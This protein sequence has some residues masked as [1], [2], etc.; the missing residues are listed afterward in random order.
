MFDEPYFRFH[1]LLEHLITFEHI[2]E[3]YNLEIKTEIDTLT[4]S[5]T[6]IYYIRR[7]DMPKLDELA[8]QYNID[9]VDD[10]AP[11][12]REH[13]SLQRLPKWLRIPAIILILIYLYFL[14]F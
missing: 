11:Y 1:I 4:D 2:V 14:I 13:F 3:K 7:T 10:Y 12:T 5:K 9:I 8:K 6:Q